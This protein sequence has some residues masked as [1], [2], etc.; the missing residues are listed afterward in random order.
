M[1]ATTM[2]V[3]IDHGHLD[4][5][6]DVSVGIECGSCGF[7]GPSD[8]NR[9]P[10]C[11]LF[12]SMTGEVLCPTDEDPVERCAVDGCPTCGERAER[13]AK[14]AAERAAW[15]RFDGDM[16]SCPDCRTKFTGWRHRETREGDFN[17]KCGG[18]LIDDGPDLTGRIAIQWAEA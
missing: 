2:F 3:C 18:D 16:G 4:P 10:D 5:D 13:E 6:W 11:N 9:C 17:C 15:E 12:A 8:G 14:Q 1:T 7:A